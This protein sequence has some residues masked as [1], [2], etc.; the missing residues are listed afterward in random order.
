MFVAIATGFCFLVCLFVFYCK[1]LVLIPKDSRSQNN[2]H[3]K[4]ILGLSSSWPLLW[5][6]GKMGSAL[7]LKLPPLKMTFREPVCKNQGSLSQP[8]PYA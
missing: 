2:Q 6:L 5:H 7:C 8:E 3:Y 1:Q 4:G